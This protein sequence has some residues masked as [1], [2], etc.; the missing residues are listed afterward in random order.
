[1]STFELLTKDGFDALEARQAGYV[2]ERLD[3]MM[4]RLQ[5]LEDFLDDYIAEKASVPAR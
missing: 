5:E 1:M 2:F 4:N 3:D